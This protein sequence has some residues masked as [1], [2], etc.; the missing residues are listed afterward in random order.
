MLLYNFVPHHLASWFFSS[1]HH[2]TQSCNY[3]EFPLLEYASLM[4]IL[5]SLVLLVVQTAIVMKN[6]CFSK[7]FFQRQWFM[8]QFSISALLGGLLRCD[9]LSDVSQMQ[10]I[11]TFSEELGISFLG[12]PQALHWSFLWGHNSRKNLNVVFLLAFFNSEFSMNYST[13]YL[14]L[15]NVL[16][17]TP[18]KVLWQTAVC[19]FVYSGCQLHFCRLLVNLLDETKKLESLRAVGFERKLKL[20]YFVFSSKGSNIG[21]I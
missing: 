17:N 3:S 12:M 16:W 7:A 14:S 11:S 2:S 21:E 10:L 13:L 15:N 8:S 5:Y 9:L 19:S 18:N 20:L 6:A 1:Q 4:L